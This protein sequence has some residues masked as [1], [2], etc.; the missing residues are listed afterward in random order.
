MRGSMSYKVTVNDDE[1]HGIYYSLD[2]PV[3]LT[4][5]YYYSKE[6]QLALDSHNRSPVP[7]HF[8]PPMIIVKLDNVT[9]I[10][11]HLDDTLKIEST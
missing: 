4:E 10:Y 5:G 9:T 7:Q 3:L 1:V 2:R 6:C 8:T 11:I